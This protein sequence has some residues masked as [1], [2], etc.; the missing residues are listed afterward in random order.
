[1]RRAA[2]LTHAFGLAPALAVGWE[3]CRAQRAAV[4]AL[5][6][7]LLLCAAWHWLVLGG[8]V[9]EVFLNVCLLLMGLSFAAS[10]IVFKYTES[11]RRQKF[12]GFPSRLFTLPV[13][14]LWLVT[15]PMLYGAGAIVL[16]YL[17]WACLIL[18]PAYPGHFSLQ[19]P[20]LYLGTG[21]ICFQAIVWSLASFPIAR[22]VALGLWGTGLTTSWIAFGSLM[23]QAQL[24][25]S[26]AQALHLSVRTTQEA[27]LL[28]FAL[29]GYGLACWSVQR[30]RRGARL[31]LPALPLA[32]WLAALAS[33]PRRPFP[34]RR[35]AQFWFEWRRNGMV[36]P[37][38]VGVLLLVVVTPCFALRPVFGPTEPGTVF[39]LL[40]WMLVLPFALAAL[41]G[42]GFGKTNFWGQGLG[43]DLGLPVFLAMR[44]LTPADW[45]A[46]KLKTAAAS[47]V[48]TWLLEAAIVPIWLLECS[49]AGRFVPLVLTL[50][51]LLWTGALIAPLLL[52]LLL[53]ILITWRLLMAN[54]YLGVLG[55]RN[56]FNAIFCALFVALFPLAIFAFWASDHQKEFKSLAVLLPWV[57]G[58]LA[59]L[60]LFKLGFALRCYRRARRQGLVSSEGALQYFVFWV[61]GTEFLLLL[62]LALPAAGPAGCVLA[63]LAFLALPLARMSLAPLA[64]ARSRSQ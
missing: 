52:L 29:A 23:G 47:A 9:H 12:N 38:L 51:P 61:W 13:S 42:P 18:R 11:D 4:G 49:A 10:F 22:L 20:C 5:G 45:L 26:L 53:A 40:F 31:R 37:L 58:D 55:N 16:L 50:P 63:C 64:F 59:L 54:L 46:V 8:R 57:A 41:I 27:I 34:S 56:L 25:V 6:G 1:M 62:V 28:A 33:A 48:L 3:I 19:F 32:R 36:L 21:M 7:A 17:G 35:S 39:L 2:S 43:K 15:V 44:P 30:Q 60:V 24:G 14:T